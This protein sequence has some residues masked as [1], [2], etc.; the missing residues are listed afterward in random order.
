MKN[1]YL[2]ILSGL[3]FV[4]T[5]CSQIQPKIETIYVGGDCPEFK[6]TL[7]INVKK[8]DED[9]A[10][11]SW[12]DIQKLKDFGAAKTTF[13]NSVKELNIKNRN[14]LNETLEKNK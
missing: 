1:L 14:L 13:N 9:Y 2:I 10:K 7:N 12:D 3:L 11:I 8:L 4:V 6:K 5:G